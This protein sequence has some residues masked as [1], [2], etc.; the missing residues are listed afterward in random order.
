[1][2]WP[3]LYN[4]VVV[5]NVHSKDHNMYIAGFIQ[6]FDILVIDILKIVLPYQPEVLLVSS[7]GK[8]IQTYLNL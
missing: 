5:F 3:P 6:V 1:M 8:L 7:L 4:S 2:S